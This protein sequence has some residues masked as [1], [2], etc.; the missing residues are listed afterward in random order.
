MGKSKT[1]STALAA[2]QA[3]ERAGAKKRIGKDKLDPRALV[4]AGFWLALTLAALAP[5]LEIS[6]E[7]PG[8]TAQYDITAP[9]RIEVIN[10]EANTRE[11]ERLRQ[12]YPR[13]WT[14]QPQVRADAVR[15][16]GLGFDII[17][18][19]K[20]ETGADVQ[21]IADEI[22]AKAT[23]RLRNEDL[24]VLYKNSNLYQ[25]H[26][27]LD[28]IIE[29]MLATRIMVADKG[30]F[31]ANRNM[32]QMALNGIPPDLDKIASD[33]DPLAW[34]V[35]VRRH[36]IENEI[37]TFYPSGE[38]RPIIEIAAKILMQVMAPNFEFDRIKT[39]ANLSQLLQLVDH[40]PVM[41]IYARG[42]LIARGGE[43]L[44]STQASA[45]H[46]VN[47]L[48]REAYYYRFAGVALLTLLSFVAVGFYW[49]RF[50][51]GVS[52]TP[53]NITLICLPVLIVVVAGRAVEF[54]ADP[55]L[56]WVLFP[57]SFIGMLSAV[58]IGPQVGFVLV[59]VTT[60]LYGV[61]LGHSP[62]FYILSLFGG[63]TSVIALQSIRSRWDVLM[64]G[65]RV[66]LVNML[67]V[68]L[69]SLFQM[70]AELDPS[71]IVGAFFNGI[72]CAIV[73]PALVAV[74]ERFFGVVTDLRLL[75]ITGPQHELMRMLEDKAPGTYQ[76]VL[77]VTKL[78]ESAAESI[79]A[80]YLLVRSGAYFHDIGKMLKPKF[81]SE[82]QVTIEDKKAHSKL[83]PYMST[84]IIKNHVKEGIELGRKY[85]L[86]P[87]VVDFI[88]QHHGTSLIRYFYY[89][90]KRRYE[91]TETTDT[92]REEEFRY[93]GPKPQ[94]VEAAIVLMADSVEATVTATFTQS[95]VNENELRRVVTQSIN[96]RFNDGQFD[97]CDLTMRDLFLIRESFI[98]T[99]KARFHH[100]IA[101]PTQ[102]GRKESP[103]QR[104]DESA[105][106]RESGTATVA[107]LA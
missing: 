97:E 10:I 45:V 59:L 14:F 61:A 107:T 77:N 72:I 64:A 22:Y 67:T 44:N 30:L 21:K 54:T 69:L 51:G 27:D 89:E 5:I 19:N 102:P 7:H 26:A 96:E 53:S 81:F 41:K 12:N 43:R 100:R 103:A 63:F 68:W 86:P 42:D 56:Q 75:E 95:Q 74:F 32:K 28:K 33:A 37:R 3:A 79:G 105:S 47:M 40:E 84:L 18:A 48:G 65:M 66:S 62:A 106:P 11:R 94:T 80:N 29:R 23:I 82:N 85:G 35:D 60:I 39:D 17:L 24:N 88:P 2:V 4:V 50:R 98:S 46:A 31:L 20:P 8:E 78:A 38:D 55:D 57:I 76:H 1:P 99:L 6:V 58:I 104:R 101:Y 49:V 13:I 91:E 83:S 16:L 73:T 36:L 90:A 93:P 92:V 25:L 15:K 70:P 87:K 71:H 52:L 34:P 9:A